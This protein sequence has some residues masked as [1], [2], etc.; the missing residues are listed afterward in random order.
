VEHLHQL[1][2]R[3]LVVNDPLIHSI[4]RHGCI[5]FNHNWHCLAFNI[6]TLVARD[7]PGQ[8]CDEAMRGFVVAVDPRSLRD[9]LGSAHV[10]SLSTGHCL[11]HERAQKLNTSK[12]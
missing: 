6:A 3:R 10:R 9:V 11:H 5:G 2:N 8:T 12:G 7:N 1:L 4:D